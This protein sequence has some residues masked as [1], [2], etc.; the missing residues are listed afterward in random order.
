MH[1]NSIQ[2]E[3]KRE[4]NCKMADPDQPSGVGGDLAEGLVAFLKDACVVVNVYGYDAARIAQ[5][6][7][8]IASWS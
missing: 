6:L 2:L 8:V 5:A 3:K 4:L 1:A 7:H